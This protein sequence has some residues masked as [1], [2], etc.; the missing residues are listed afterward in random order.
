MIQTQPLP[1]FCMMSFFLQF[2]FEGVPQVMMLLAQKEAQEVH[3]LS[4]CLS[5][6]HSALCIMF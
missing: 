1:P 5:V 3:L 2:F 6:C 4:F